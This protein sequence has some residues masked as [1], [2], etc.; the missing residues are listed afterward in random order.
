MSWV[1]KMGITTFKEKCPSL[2]HRNILQIDKDI[3][4][5]D[6]CTVDFCFVMRL[7]LEP[8]VW[9]ARAAVSGSG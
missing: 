2:V 1:S 5:A 7:E 4:K 9:L 6:I 8:P 3:I